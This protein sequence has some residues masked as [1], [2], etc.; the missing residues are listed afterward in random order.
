[1]P[2]IDK[3]HFPRS[4]DAAMIAAM[5]SPESFPLRPHAELTARNRAVVARFVDLFYRQRQVRAAFEAH[6][7]ASRY[8]QHNPTLPDGRDAA[9]M[10][11]EPKFGA[12]G[13]HAEV[14]RVLVDG[15]LAV[16]H[17]FVRPSPEHRGAAVADFFRLEDGVIVE[18][19]DVLQ[20]VPETVVSAHPMA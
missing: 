14:R 11:L 16:V 5:T 6:V 2:A 9:I 15:D 12:A 8:I 19:W 13:F 18:H 20:L 7:S 17:L 10:A 4:P 3:L 1:M